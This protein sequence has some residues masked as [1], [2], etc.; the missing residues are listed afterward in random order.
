MH[1]SLCRLFQ[2]CGEEYVKDYLDDTGT[3]KGAQ[4]EKAALQTDILLEAANKKNGG[5]GLPDR[6]SLRSCFM[7]IRFRFWTV[8]SQFDGAKN[9][10]PLAQRLL[11]C[12]R[13][14]GESTKSILDIIGPRTA[15]GS[16]IA[17]PRHVVH[18]NTRKQ[19]AKECDT[20]GSSSPR[21]TQCHACLSI[22]AVRKEQEAAGD[23]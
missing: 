9:V 15:T 12:Y 13:A 19:Q 1:A 11:A 5:V 22:A 6:H 3:F 8:T 18:S 14:M 10:A 21:R 16:W 7:Q 23:R 17:P 20:E 2:C 4:P